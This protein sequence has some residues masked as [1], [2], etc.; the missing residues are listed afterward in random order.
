MNRKPDPYK[1]DPFP[2][3]L[4]VWG[5]PLGVIAAAVLLY[6]RDPGYK[7]LIPCVF[8]QVTGLYCVG[9]GTTRA[10]HELLHGRFLDA[11]SFNVFMMIMIWLVGYTMLAYWLKRLLRRQLLPKIRLRRWLIVAVI[12]SAVLFL[13]MRN[14]RAWPFSWLA[15]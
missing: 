15:P 4:I 10:F 13:V 14:I 3:L 12:T 5:M 6:F 1:N 11:L 8:Y 2:R 9:C 7:G